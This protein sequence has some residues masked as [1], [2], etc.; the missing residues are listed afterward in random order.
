MSNLYN[1]DYEIEVEFGDVEP[2]EDA[3]RIISERWNALQVKKE[4][5]R[6]QAIADISKH[7][8]DE[9]KEFKSVMD[10]GEEVKTEEG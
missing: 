8:Q 3:I 7:M 5:A 2:V 6:L 1:S 4:E 10:E 9:T